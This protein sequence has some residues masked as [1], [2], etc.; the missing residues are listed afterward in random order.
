MVSRTRISKAK[1]AR[2]RLLSQE[3][4]VQRQ[5]AIDRTRSIDSKAGFLV[6]AGGLL[7]AQAVPELTK[8]DLSWLALVLGVA[9]LVFA[10]VVTLLATAAL[11]PLKIFELQP[12]DF[13][14][15]WIDSCEPE[16]ALED[17][18]LE[19]KAV[20]ISRRSAKNEKRARLLK[21][22]FVVLVIGIVAAIGAGIVGAL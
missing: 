15:K 1:L 16:G 5:L 14:K 12:K 17:Y 13:V 9:R 7:A 19:V 8:A 18:I 2:I 4:D 21:A 20:T 6:L 3:L 11:W 22:G 10:L